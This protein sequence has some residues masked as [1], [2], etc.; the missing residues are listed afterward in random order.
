MVSEKNQSNNVK[1]K[2]IS[3]DSLI[4]DG[5]KN[6]QMKLYDKIPETVP[7]ISNSESKFLRNIDKSFNIIQYLFVYR[8]KYIMFLN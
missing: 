3:M 5:E 7:T 1:E 2:S 6:K 8:I 4:N